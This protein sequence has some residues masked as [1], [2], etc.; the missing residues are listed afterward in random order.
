MWTW[1]SEAFGASLP[2]Q[3]PSGLGTFVF[4]LRFSGQ[5]YDQETGLFYNVFRDYDPRTGRYIE[6]DPIGL[7]GGINTY[8]YVEN[9]TLSYIDPLGLDRTYSV[10]QRLVTFS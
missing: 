9:N 6:S 10:G 3:N 1:E 5:Y 2:D 8:A 7:N 4:N